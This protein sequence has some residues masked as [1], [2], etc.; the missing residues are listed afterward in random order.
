LPISHRPY[1]GIAERE[2]NPFADFRH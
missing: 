1:V 2:L